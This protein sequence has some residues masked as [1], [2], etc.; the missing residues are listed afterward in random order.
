MNTPFKL[1]VKIRWV[2]QLDE[3]SNVPFTR[4][5]I[6]I[7]F[8]RNFA[9]LAIFTD[10]AVAPQDV[11]VA[12]TTFVADSNQLNVAHLEFDAGSGRIIGTFQIAL[13]HAETY[14]D[15]AVLFVCVF[16][17]IKETVDRGS[18]L[19]CDSFVHGIHTNTSF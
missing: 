6:V 4:A 13:G 19:N 2:M 16:D 3:G 12:V 9:T 15:F 17:G 1:S 18:I 11:A 7:R 5:C 8:E 14:L 10:R